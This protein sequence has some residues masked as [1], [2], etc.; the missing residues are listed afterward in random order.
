MVDL[1]KQKLLI[2]AP[3]PDDEVLGCGGFIKKIKDA[4][5]KVYVLFLTVGETQEY[6]HNGATT[7]D[8]R[9][10]EIEKVAKFMQYDDY[11]IAFV[12]NTYHLQ[13]DQMPQKQIITEIENGTTISL[14]K[15]KPTTIACPQPDDYNQDH[16]AAAQAVFTATR[17]V[18]DDI[19]PFQNMV[20]GFESVATADW[21][22]TT[23]PNHNFFV[24]LS[25]TE[26]DAKLAA[27]NLYKSQVRTGAHPRSIQ[28]LKN[29]AHFR[30]LQCGK[31]AAEAYNCYRQL[32]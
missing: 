22:T 25:D 8:Q 1:K 16:R 24:E 13:L 14:N 6:S 2:V 20:I 9:I 28:S 17:P 32:V 31:S 21:T 18:P 4:G 12:G 23:V 30:G 15:I 26:L 5:G 3:H 27:I 11:K 7:S 19:K 10:A 29:L